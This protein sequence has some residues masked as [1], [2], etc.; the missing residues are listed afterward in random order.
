MR[1]PGQ[2]GRPLSRTAASQTWLDLLL[3]PRQGAPAVPASVYNVAAQLL[4]REQGVD[5]HPAYS[6]THLS[7]GLW[8][9]LRAAR[10]TT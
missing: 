9:T 6:R 2:P 5:D 4:A 3:P 1:S 7:G 8:L 10:M